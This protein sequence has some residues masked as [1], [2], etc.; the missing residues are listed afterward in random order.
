VSV[1]AISAVW[2]YSESSGTALLVL[3][4]IA[5]SADHDGTNAWPSQGTLATKTRLSRRTVQ[6]K[7]HD[8]V[9]LGELAV[10]PG[11]AHIRWDRRP[12]GYEVRLPGMTGCRPVVSAGRQ[13]VVDGAS[14][15]ASR[16]VTD[17]AQPVLTRPE[18]EEIHRMFEAMR[19][20]L[21]YGPNP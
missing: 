17:D 3:L 4:A 19:N 11:P 1:K 10:V 15:D 13:S 9:T 18:P 14:N 12:N 7:I 16:G 21:R 6:R 20:S 8:L 2:D 5:D